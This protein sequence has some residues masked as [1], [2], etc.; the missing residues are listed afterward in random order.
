MVQEP[1]VTVTQE[2]WDRSTEKENEKFSKNLWDSTQ[3]N[4]SK[5]NSKV[6][7]L[8]RKNGKQL[9]EPCMTVTQ[10]E[11]DSSYMRMCAS[12]H[13]VKE[14]TVRQKTKYL[15]RRKYV[16]QPKLST[17]QQFLRQRYRCN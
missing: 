16:K 2:G 5:A 4:N 1:C 9:Q 17:T 13:K 7:S 8:P 15:R 6:E 10:K 14:V 12:L 3:H 11:L